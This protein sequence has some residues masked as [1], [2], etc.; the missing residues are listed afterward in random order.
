MAKQVHSTTS[1]SGLAAY[2]PAPVGWYTTILLALLYW[3]SILDRSIISLLV[4]P[5]RNDIG[6]SDT[7][8][9]MLHGL[10]F[11]IT[12]SLF[13]I[14]AGTLADRH[15]RRLI[16]FISVTLWSLATAGCG[17]ARDFWQLL[18][19]RV[20]VGAGEA[21]LSPAASS[22]I[23]DLFPPSRLTMALAV[24]SMGAS[25]G[26]GCALLFGG[27]LVDWVYSLEAISVP[28]LGIIRPWQ[29]IFLLIG[30]PGVAIAWLS[31]S[32]PEPARRGRRASSAAT[33][34]ANNYPALF[35]FM[36]SRR[37]F[38]THHYIGFGLA[39]MGFVGGTAWYP[40]HLAREFGWSGSEIGL[41]L[42]G[43]L[44]IGGI[45]GKG[46]AGYFIGLLYE[47]GHRDAQFLWYAS[48]LVL[49]TPVAVFMA[50]SDNPWGFIVS[51]AV[52]QILLGAL[53]AVYMS[54]LNMVTPNELRGA[55][56]AFYTAT[57]GL[58]AMSMGPILIA[59]ISDYVLGGDA[60]GKGMASNFLLCLPVAAAVLFRGRGAMRRAV[61][62]S[63]SPEQA[64]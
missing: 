6:I 51:Y 58:L 60:I 1:E 5:I 29:A 57:M 9:G 53:P 59:A 2:P 26:A 55:G 34:S 28:V 40:A 12:F 14:A 4:D 18:L 3:L 19:A 46:L 8:F 11:A 22:M 20:G 43:A 56:I 42:G 15:S 54:S 63:L 64:G 30:L 13:G 17:L 35:R 50:L 39:S 24:Y 47:R 32:M 21:G 61:D 41:G 31:F 52:F 33:G 7:Q 27:M 62:D 48:A 16:V 25:V 49:A 36:A 37:Q 44:I 38:F 45:L 23:S 10:A